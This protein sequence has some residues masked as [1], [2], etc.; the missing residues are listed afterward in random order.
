MIIQFTLNFLLTFILLY[1]YLSRLNYNFLFDR[2]PLGLGSKKKTKTGSGIVFSIIIL[3]NTIYY[4]FDQNIA[5]LLPNRFYVFVLSIALLSIISYFDDI[6]SIDP[7]L[8]LIFQ[9]VIIYFSLTLIDLYHFVLPLKLI[10]FLYL[11]FWIYITN[12]TNFIDGSDGYLTVNVISFSIGILIINQ[13]VPDLFFSYYLVIILLPIL[14]SFI[15]FNKPK[16]K[17]YMG[18]TGSIILGYVIGFCL[19]EILSSKYW[20]L[21]IS[22]YSYVI[23]DCSLT[24]L[25]KIMSGKSVF[26]RNFSY[27]FQIPIKKLQ[28]NNFKVLGISIIYNLINLLVVYLVLLLDNPNLVFLS[29]ILSLI[30]I[31]I[32]MKIK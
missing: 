15:Y 12:I 22:L 28:K 14:I 17:L 23:L 32:F 25:K 7:R 24:K 20:Y 13:F 21:C 26:N 1:L 19:L 29:L 9:I 27:F 8:R 4:F 10:I 6:N 30:K 3:I 5:E 31:Y 18:D 11:C 2:N 16:A